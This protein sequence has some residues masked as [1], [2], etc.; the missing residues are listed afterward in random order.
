M[1][2]DA[3]VSRLT[4]ARINKV[5]KLLDRLYTSISTVSDLQAEANAETNP[6]KRAWGLESAAKQGKK[7]GNELIEV[8]LS[9]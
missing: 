3:C 2:H 7:A 6:D 4:M 5:F 1:E 9:V 8:S